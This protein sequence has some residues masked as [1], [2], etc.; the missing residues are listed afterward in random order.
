MGPK[1]NGALLDRPLADVMK[2][3][4]E[5]MAYLVI[6][7]LAFASRFWDLGARAMSFDETTHALYAY[8]LYSGQGFVHNPLMHGPF[9]FHANAL[10]YFLFGDN[11]YT[12]RIVPA[13]F[14]V[15]LVMSPLLLRRWLGRAGALITSALILVSPSLLYYSRYIRNEIYMAFWMVLLAAALFHFVEERR[16]RW[17]YV[18][19]A[20]L[21]LSLATKE[22]AYLFG[23]TGATFLAGTVLWE[24]VPRSRR[25][26]LY[27]AGG[28]LSASCLLAAYVLGRPPAEGTDAATAAGAA[29]PL[30]DALLTVVGGTI[31]AFLVA[32]TLIPARHPRPG[33]IAQVLRA[34]SWR[35]WLTA[36]AIMFVIYALLFTT[37]FTNPLGL[38]TGIAGSLSY[39]LA[40]QGVQRG[41]QPLYYYFLLLI[42]YEFVPLLF[43]AA[44][45]A[46]YLLRRPASAGAAEVVVAAPA[47]DDAVGADV[48]AEPAPDHPTAGPLFVPFLLFWALNSLFLYSWAGERMPWMVVHQ[49]LPLLLLAGKFLGDL[50]GPVEWRGIWRRGGALLALLLLLTL[51]GSL[52][53]SRLQLMNNLLTALPIALFLLLLTVLVARRL[54][55]RPS[56]LVA[57]ATIVV[58]LSLFSVRFAWLASFVNYDYA[59]EPLVYAH[60][61][62]DVKLT[63][64]EIAHISQQTVGD[65]TIEVAYDVEASWPIEWYMRQYPN[66]KYYGDTPN[67]EILDVPL[68]IA[69]SDVD[70]RV[71][72]FL[73]ERYLRF[74]RRGL[75]WPTEEYRDLTWARI[76]DILGSPEK[77]QALWNILYYRQYPRTLE[78]WYNVSYFYFYVRKDVAQQLWNRGALL[79]EDLV[80]PPDRYAEAHVDLPVAGV[81]GHAEGSSGAGIEPGQFN[82]PRG[83]AV[84]PDGSVYVTDSDNHR[85]QVFDGQGRLLRTWGSRCALDSG[86]GCAT[87]GGEGQFQEPWGIAVGPDGRVYVADTW[88]HRIQAF[89][90]EGNYLTQWGTYGQTA[91]ALDQLYGPRDVA[92]D[93]AGRVYVTDT[94]NKRVLVY[95]QAGAL[96]AQ[97]GGAGSEPGRFEEPVGIALDTE[98]NVYVADTWNRRVQVFDADFRF[99]RQWPVEAWYGESVVNKPYLAVDARGRV[100]VSDPE[101]YR[102]AVFGPEGDLL[103]TVGR[104]GFEPDAFSLPTGIDVGPDGYIFVADTNG[105][106]IVK[107][108][109]LP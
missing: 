37:F 67:R 103:A 89:D 101:G 108:E 84:G 38:A 58:S 12:A 54:G 49:V 64:D 13:L 10:V 1:K 100:Y 32:G 57:A 48:D 34:L 63:M 50:F 51:S 55:A 43:G 8:N 3:D 59:T 98:G 105:Q 81:W 46:Y 69:S 30:L 109:P 19:A 96:L 102:L 95:D 68:I 17:F 78:D 36:A 2:L 92:V 5:R 7:L 75:W 70:D 21:M 107:L 80:L 31:P 14:G 23:F 79:P 41:S 42:L 18:G 87:P 85:V 27:L 15:L 97:W 82:H 39:W 91:D 99:L 77:R 66:R 93:A 29:V 71:R 44:G 24:R 106:R 11:D 22:N 104:Y 72:P 47:A 25:P 4:W 88:N 9:L 28:L 61:T 65:Q 40:Q 62:P 73:G 20:V 35:Q 74:R 90:A 53:L 60:G 16:P 45:A 76:G 83:L 33:R 6:L 52:G 26:W 94:G 56:L 86:E